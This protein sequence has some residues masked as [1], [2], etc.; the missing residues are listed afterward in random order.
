MRAR[1]WDGEYVVFNSASG[2][3]HLLGPAAMAALNALQ[4]GTLDQQALAYA[5]ASWCADDE[6]RAGA[7][8]SLLDDLYE[9][10]LIVQ[11]AP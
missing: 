5:V 1:F 11:V 7:A 8:A 3:T 9:L 4:A 10:G 6:D 2:D